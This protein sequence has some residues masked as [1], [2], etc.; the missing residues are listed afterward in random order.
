MRDHMQC[1]GRTWGLELWGSK[2]CSDCHYLGQVVRGTARATP[3]NPGGD[4][5]PGPHMSQACAVPLKDLPSPSF[6]SQV[7][8]VDLCIGAKECVFLGAGVIAHRA[9]LGTI[10]YTLLVL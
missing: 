7:S 4:A 8:G 2:H 1:W 10:P 6:A 3:H 9:D 5:V